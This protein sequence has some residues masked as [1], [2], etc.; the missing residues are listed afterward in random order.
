MSMQILKEIVEAE[1]KIGDMAD[2]ARKK[3]EQMITEEDAAAKAS[4]EKKKKE[5]EEKNREH[6]GQM[7][8]HLEEKSIKKIEEAKKQAAEI[9]KKAE[10]GIEKAAD[11]IYG[12]FLNISK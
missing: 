3:A 7:R 4:I 6:L 11:Y 12:E 9:R 2:R 10:K 5:L 1:K 8:K